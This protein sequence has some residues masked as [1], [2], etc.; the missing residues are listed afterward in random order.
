MGNVLRTTG[1]SVKGTEMKLYVQE[2]QYQTALR[3]WG[4]FVFLFCFGG[5]CQYHGFGFSFYLKV[6]QRG[7][8]GFCLN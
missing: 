2:I 6:G 4:F 7:V 8:L 3:V 1:I 5:A